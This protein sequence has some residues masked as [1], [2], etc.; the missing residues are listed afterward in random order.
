MILAAG[1]GE[2][3]RPLTDT[4]PKPLVQVGGHSLIEWHLKHLAES[5]IKDIVINI[6]HLASQIR[7]ALGN[8]QKFNVNIV[9]SEEPAVALETG[10]GI[11]QALT[12]LGGDPFVV[13]NGDIWTDYPFSGLHAPEGLAHLVLVGNPA[14]HPQGDF[15]LQNNRVLENSH[16]ERYTF[17]G[18]GVYRPE[19]FSECKPGR[20]SLTP[21]LREAM[22]NG[23]VSGEYFAGH[24][25]DVG[26]PVRLQHV[27]DFVSKIQEGS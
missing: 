21:V 12:L 26:A 14:Q 10:G 11:F 16:G 22:K 17:S 24:W 4:T 3:L 23:H 8:G 27:Q 7:D 20:F 13:V 25:F 15:V 6:S 19:L 9:Y 5:G 18:I 2:R 1:R